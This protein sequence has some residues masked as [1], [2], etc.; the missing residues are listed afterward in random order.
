MNANISHTD[1]VTLS[2]FIKDS[3]DELKFVMSKAIISDTK[4]YEET[5]NKTTPPIF[6]KS[7]G[8]CK[9]FALAALRVLANKHLSKQED[10][11]YSQDG[12]TIVLENNQ[13]S[14][15]DVEHKLFIIAFMDL[16]NSWKDFSGNVIYPVPDTTGQNCPIERFSLTNEMYEGSYG[17]KRLELFEHIYQQFDADPEASINLFVFHLF[18]LH[19]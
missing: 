9:N 5:V 7:D 19:V 8:L 1:I 2:N 18:T 13:F 6:L 14:V 10:N 12:D 3:L 15:K 17:K 4:E 16:I 11:T